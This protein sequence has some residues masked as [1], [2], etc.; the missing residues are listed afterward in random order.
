MTR[1]RR[2]A[3]WFGTSLAV[4][5][6]ATPA[7]AQWS[8]TRIDPPEGPDTAGPR[9]DLPDT[10]WRGGADERREKALDPDFALEIRFGPYWPEIDEEFG[11]P[12]PYERVFDNDPQFYFGL[13]VDWLPFR[14]P[15]LGKAGAG[16]GWGITPATG[17]AVDPATNE[18]SEVESSITI[19]PMHASLVL[20]GDELMRRTH[21]PL[22]PYGKFGFGFAT[23]STS[24]S[25]GTSEV[26]E[27]PS[28]A[29]TCAEG[30]DTTLG[31]H[32]ALGL[33][34]ALDWVEPQRTKN[35]Q[36]MGIG[37]LYLFGEW[38]HA[39]LDGLGSR[40][41]LHVGTSTFIGGVALD[42]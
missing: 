39:A 5:S 10:N 30:E 15:Y 3:I 35:L 12:G 23:W 21:V 33:A 24:T 34:L 11:S 2:L 9:T 6:A 25:A 31:L 37:H 17:Y 38:M 13:E 29:D 27:S 32:F 7:M 19:M 22:V 8:S 18:P 41:Q 16:L 4:V 14:I 42:F 40:P 26:C 28:D 36:S 20:R 1:G